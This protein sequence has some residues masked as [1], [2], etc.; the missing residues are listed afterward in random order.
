M[1]YEE[2]SDYSLYNMEMVQYYTNMD[3]SRGQYQVIWT[4]GEQYCPRP[5][6]EGNIALPR[7]I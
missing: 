4:E 5:K 6:A 2:N 7:S 3:W 1:E